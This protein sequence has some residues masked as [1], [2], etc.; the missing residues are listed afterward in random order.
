MYIKL[1]NTNYSKNESLILHS[2]ENLKIEMDRVLEDR[3][4]AMTAHVYSVIRTRS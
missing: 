4:N 3:E 1:S 2:H